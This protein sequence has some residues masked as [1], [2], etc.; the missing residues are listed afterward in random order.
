[1]EKCQIMNQLKKIMSKKPKHIAECLCGKPPPDFTPEQK[2]EF[3]RDKFISIGFPE[4]TVKL[5]ITEI[6]QARAD[7]DKKYKQNIGFLRQWLNESRITDE[8]KLV[9]NEEIEHFLNLK[10]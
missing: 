6:Q 8:S 5:V 3:I 4:S 7:Q 2:D 10:K 9:T 1:M